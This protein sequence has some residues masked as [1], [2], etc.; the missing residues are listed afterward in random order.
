MCSIRRCVSSKSGY[1]AVRQSLNNF[2]TFIVKCRTHIFQKHPQHCCPQ[3]GPETPWASQQC[4]VWQ[5]QPSYPTAPEHRLTPSVPS[6]IP[7]W[8][9]HTVPQPPA[10][11]LPQRGPV[12]TGRLWRQARNGQ[13]GAWGRPASATP[14]A[15]ANLPQAWGRWRGNTQ[16]RA[17]RGSGHGRAGLY[18]PLPSSRSR[19]SLGWEM[20]FQFPP[21]TACRSLT[22]T[23]PPPQSPLTATP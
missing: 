19:L 3:E 22:S 18:A 21:I 4:C 8:Q 5:G 20:H 11:S 2:F 12:S 23:N 10:L 14:P 7:G 13:P 16:L 1:P 17:L 6:P 15:T 9:G